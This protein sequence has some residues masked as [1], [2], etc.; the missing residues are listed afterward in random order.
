MGSACPVYPLWGS[1]SCS[2]GVATGAAAVGVA[3]V[4]AARTGAA[5]LCRQASTIAPI[6]AERGRRCGRRGVMVERRAGSAELVAMGRLQ[7]RCQASW[8][9][10][11]FLGIAG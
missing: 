9:Q 10:R 6:E 7:R 8:R 4:D 3:P 5:A 1:A 2:A 11:A